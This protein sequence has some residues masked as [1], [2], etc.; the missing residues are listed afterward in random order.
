MIQYKKPG[1]RAKPWEFEMWTEVAEMESR[2]LNNM[3]RKLVNDHVK[4]VLGKDRFMNEERL[5][6]EM[7]DL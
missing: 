4:N 6:H 2:S 1:L 3:I 5:Y 7:E